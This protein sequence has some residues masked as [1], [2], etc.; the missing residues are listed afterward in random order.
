M[1]KQ[2]IAVLPTPWEMI[3]MIIGWLKELFAKAD[4]LPDR[5]DNL[6]AA[7]S[8]AVARD[9]MGV[10]R[11]LHAL[12]AWLHDK[13]DDLDTDMDW[14]RDFCTVDLGIAAIKG[15]IES[16]VILPPYDWFKLDSLDFR[17]WLT[18]YGA[19]T[20]SVNSAYINLVKFHDGGFTHP[21][22]IAIVS[23]DSHPIAAECG[24][25]SGTIRAAFGFWC[26]MDFLMKAGK[27]VAQR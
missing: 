12:Q 21:H 11:E 1:A 23:V 14:R 22:D 27:V 6:E 19:H 4:K 13:A 15:T 24:L 10:Y 26:R 2:Q 9:A 8:N 25:A 16:G 17:D 3:E 18:K 7:R 5:H 20:I